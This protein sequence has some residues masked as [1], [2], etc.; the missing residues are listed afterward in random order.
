NYFARYGLIRELEIIGTLMLELNQMVKA[1]Q[2]HIKKLNQ[3][4]ARTNFS[5]S[6]VKELSET[7]YIL[8][9][10]LL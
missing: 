2:Q 6:V 4:A 5:H 7:N 9:F 3:Q 8:N 1:Y 10:S